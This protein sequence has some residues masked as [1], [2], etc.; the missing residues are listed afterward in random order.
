MSKVEIWI[1][2]RHLRTG[3]WQTVLTIGAVAVAVILIVV[4]QS[5]STAG[6]RRF[7]TQLT[8]GVAHVTVKPPDPEPR[9]LS[10]MADGN[11]GSEPAAPAEPGQDAGRPLIT[12]RIERQA[13]QRKLIDGWPRTVAI[14]RQYPHVRALAPIVGGQ[15]FIIRGA[16]SYGVT[17]TGANPDDYEPLVNLNEDMAR[18]RYVGI[19]P[20]DVVIGW[21]LADELHVAVGD[22]I[23]I[24]S[25]EGV[26][27]A[28]TVAGLFDTGQDQSDRTRAFVTLGTAQSLFGTGSAVTAIAIQLDDLNQARSVARQIE[29][30]LPVQADNWMDE[31]AQ[32]LGLI[33]T[34]RAFRVMIMLVS[35]IGSSLGIASVLIV[36][37][38]RRSREIGILKAMGARSGQ[39]LAVFTLEGLFIALLGSGL[40]VLLG[41]GILAA[42]APLRQPPRPSGLPPDVLLPVSFSAVIMAQAVAASVVATLIASI[43]P[44]R[45]AAA[46]DPVEVIR[47]G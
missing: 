43:L 4:I 30:A 10:P 40:G 31:F 12:T 19:G 44:A 26:S 42:V 45:R 3:G 33:R 22:R 9:P 17:L 29:D 28:F 8:S 11:T 27:E 18:G 5:L 41:S 25:S 32:F 21:S 1:A 37:V 46:L 23:R 24:T 6:L 47:G 15:A 7:V 13:L 39:I 34:Q 36:A 20:Q 35:L 14:L 2:W 16:R 38:L